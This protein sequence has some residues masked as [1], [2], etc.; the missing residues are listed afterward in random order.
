MKSARQAARQADRQAARP[1]PMGIH[2]CGKKVRSSLL[3]ASMVQND[4]LSIFMTE[5][6][7]SNE[8]S[9]KHLITVKDFSSLK[10]QLF[11][12]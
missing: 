5:V 8:S 2:D 6:T 7:N 12:Q 9:I 1:A 3:G 4:S 10:G 11:F